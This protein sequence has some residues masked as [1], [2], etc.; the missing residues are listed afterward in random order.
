VLDAICN[1]P[2]EENDIKERQKNKYKGKRL[3]NDFKDL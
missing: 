2:D 1:I 3:D